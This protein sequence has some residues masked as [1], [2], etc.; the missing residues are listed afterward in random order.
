MR[1]RI[2]PSPAKQQ[3]AA[4]TPR[5]GLCELKILLRAFDAEEVG[6]PEE[7]HFFNRRNGLGA[8]HAEA[9]VLGVGVIPDRVGN[10]GVEH[11]EVFVR[12]DAGSAAQ[13]L[14]IVIP[15]ATTNDAGIALG[16]EKPRVAHT[17]L[18]LGERVGMMRL[19]SPLGDIAVH[20]VESPRVGLFEAYFLISKISVVDEPGILAELLDI[21]TE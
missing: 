9:D 19:D 8:H 1:Q 11:F 20:V 15:R 7:V 14:G 3:Q 12:G 5:D 13:H 4:R 2:N 16:G 6:V 10:L 21:V 18:E 17:V